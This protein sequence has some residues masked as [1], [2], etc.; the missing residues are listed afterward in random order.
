MRLL[1][2]TLTSVFGLGLCGAPALAQLRS[3]APGPNM[4]INEINDGGERLQLTGGEFPDAAIPLKIIREKVKRISERD[5]G[6]L[7][8]TVDSDEM[9][10][11]VEQVFNEARPLNPEATHLLVIQ[12][13]NDFQQRIPAQL[14]PAL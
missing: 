5:G 2:T 1:F 11:S 10:K 14:T 4:Y 9:R 7:I 8:V 13:T 3:Q 12:V 6:N